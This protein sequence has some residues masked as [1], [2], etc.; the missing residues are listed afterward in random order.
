MD[1]RV[2]T[3]TDPSAVYRYIAKPEETLLYYDP[4]PPLPPQV[5]WAR[6][7]EKLEAMIATTHGSKRRWKQHRDAELRRSA[8][9]GVA[10]VSASALPMEFA[11][12]E[13]LRA[14]QSML[15]QL[16]PLCTLYFVDAL[17]RKRAAAAVTNAGSQDQQRAAAERDKISEFLQTGCVGHLQYVMQERLMTMT[18]P[19]I[20][21]L[22]KKLRQY[23]DQPEFRGI[24]FVDRRCV[25]SPTACLRA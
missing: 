12:V 3:A 13:H 16:G 10:S 17:L 21:A 8:R 2:Y 6:V 7:I 20:H 11:L 9:G 23:H 14:I 15:V 4:P 5:G 1:C 25:A 19:K 22:L 24:V 18:T